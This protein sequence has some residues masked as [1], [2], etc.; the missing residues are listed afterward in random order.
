MRRLIVIALLVASP[1]MADDLR[2]EAATHFA[3]GQAAQAE[4][5]FRDAIA[6]YDQA[7]AL[8]PHGNALYNIAVC[9]EKLGDWGNAADY[10]QRYLDREP[11]ATDATEVTAKI[12][13][14]RTRT[15]AT[16]P[17][18][19][20]NDHAAPPTDP[21]AGGGVTSWAPPVVPEPPKWHAGAAY[22]LGFGDA[23]VQRLTAYAG[24]RW[25]E[26]FETD[27]VL[28][29]FGKNDHGL[30]MIGR[31]LVMPRPYVVPFV[32]AAITAGYAKQDAS[33]IAETK[34]P[35]GFELGGG[36]RAGK[37]G[38][39]EVDVV[40][41]WIGNGWGADTTMA[42]SYANDAFAVAFDVGVTFDFPFRL[43]AADR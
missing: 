8:V 35:L 43:T 13:E 7:N 20:T 2:K 24:R 12:R 29:F 5:R 41:R 30:G 17:P 37:Q 10:Y 21:S 4:G 26:R 3:A 39:L 18:P 9:Y 16:E 14:L 23:P 6:E 34:F 22:G 42:D 38:W 27:V 25:A 40:A 31:L 33:S 28:G 32:R 19:T 11:G 1:A 36:V 15:P